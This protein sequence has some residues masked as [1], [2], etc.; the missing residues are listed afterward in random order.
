MFHPGR[1]SFLSW[2]FFNDN[3]SIANKLWSLN[4][5]RI[6]FLRFACAIIVE[7]RYVVIE[8]SWGIWNW[9]LLRRSARDFP[10]INV[11]VRDDLSAGC[12][13]LLFHSVVCFI[14]SVIQLIFNCM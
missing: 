7:N 2:R 14:N 10:Y 3:S 8:S 5:E 13:G 9:F 11:V 6:Y 12:F 4:V 1:F